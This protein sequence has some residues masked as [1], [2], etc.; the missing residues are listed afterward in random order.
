MGGPE[1]PTSDGD[2]SVDDFSESKRRQAEIMAAIQKDAD[3]AKKPDEITDEF[4]IDCLY[5]NELGDGMLY[6]ALH[7]KDLIYEKN[8]DTWLRWAGHYWEIDNMRQAKKSVAVVA[9]RYLDEATALVDQI[10]RAKTKDE[11]QRL[12][13][14]Q[15]NIYKRV[16]RL[17]SDRGGKNAL[18]FAHTNPSNS[19]EAWIDWFDRDPM[20]IPCKNGPIDAA[21]GNHS[22]GRQ[23][24]YFMKA[25]PVEYK[26]VDEPA[27]RWERFLMEVFEEDEN[28]IAYLQRLFG[29]CLTGHI[30]EHVLPIFNGRGR[31]GKGTII[32]T[33]K[34]HVM[35]PL[36]SPIQAEMLLNQGRA[37]NTAGPSADI[38][39]LR[40]LRL[41][42]ASETDE[43]TRFSSS[44]VKWLT[45]GD[46]LKGR[47]PHDRY[48]TE[49]VP[50]HKLILLTNDLPHV[51]AHDYAFWERVHVVP[52]RLS[53]VTHKPRED[54]ERPADR[55]LPAKL[56]EE[57][58]GILAWMVRG[59]VAWQDQGL[60]PPPIITHATAKYRRGEDQIADF[61]DECCF[62]RPSLRT[63]ASV[64]YSAFREWW[65]ENISNKPLSQ[66]KFGKLFSQTFQR[67]KEGV[68]FY[69]GVGIKGGEE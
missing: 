11:G 60:N 12:K 4:V 44:R 68:A 35:G 9:Q 50:T 34:K 69:L 30:T 16:L 47:N 13:D 27:P 37:R 7:K 55:D 46:T 67:E 14:R 65:K 54:Y 19:L 57:A 43:G 32:E 8:S 38:M 58:S 10:A 51:S 59:C 64:I 61:I 24:Q 45:G 28:I 3:E 66:Q 49:F 41:A 52:F 5:A 33:I 22:P 63:R 6:A 15:D 39:S 53:Y 23:D 21:T 62:K 42:Y 29:Y 40:G 26:G 1:K 48:E 25:C 36:A 2:K 31:N 18:E 17:R 20:Q 56:A